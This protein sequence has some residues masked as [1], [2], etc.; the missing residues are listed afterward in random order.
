MSYRALGVMDTLG[1]GFGT[2][3]MSWEESLALGGRSGVLVSVYS[4]RNC[5]YPLYS[6]S[7]HSYLYLLLQ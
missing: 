5:K 1:F 2:R 4:D 6:A 7:Y 3:S